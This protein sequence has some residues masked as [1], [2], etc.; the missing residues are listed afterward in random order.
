MVLTESSGSRT[1]AHF[2]EAIFQSLIGI[3][4]F[5]EAKV[6]DFDTIVVPKTNIVRFEICKIDNMYKHVRDV[7]MLKE[8]LRS[9]GDPS[10]R[11]LCQYIY[12][13]RQF[14]I[15]ANV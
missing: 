1:T 4:L 5:G 13:E 8:S 10:C 14:P 15:C 9:V 3:E 12:L 6:I 2:V 7:R 11:V